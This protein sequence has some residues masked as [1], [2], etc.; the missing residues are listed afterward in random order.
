MH[1][2][3]VFGPHVTLGEMPWLG[4]RKTGFGSS[5]VSPSWRFT[6]SGMAVTAATARVSVMKAVLT[7]MA[8]TTGRC[9][10]IA[11]R[12]ATRG[13]EGGTFWGPEVPA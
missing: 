10:R 8:S 9:R 13:G 3:R 12:R 6:Y 11:L 7:G 1:R 5:R 2:L 4:F